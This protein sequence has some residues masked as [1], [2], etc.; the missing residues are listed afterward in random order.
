MEIVD[1]CAGSDDG[2]GKINVDFHGIP[3]SCAYRYPTILVPMS[4]SEIY[5][6]QT[7][8]TEMTINRWELSIYHNI[9]ILAK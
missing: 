5:A 8:L 4:K 1:R 6:I 7:L 3:Q 9:S 2:T